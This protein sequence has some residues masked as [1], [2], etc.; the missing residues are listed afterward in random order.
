[1]T[2]L[3]WLKLRKKTAP[4]LPYE[5]PIF[6]GNKSNGEFFHD[7]TPQERRIRAEIL[8][9]CD[10]KARKLGMDR[11]EF[12]ASAMGMCTSL[13]VL[14]LAS[15]CGDKGGHMP[16][17]AADPIMGGSQANAGGFGGIGGVGGVNAAGGSGGG[18][19]IAMGPMA[20]AGVGGAGGASG[21]DAGSAMPMPDGEC[22]EWCD[23]RGQPD[24]GFCIPREATLDCEMADKLLG[25]DEF[26]FDLQT[27]HVNQGEAGFVL[28][29]CQING[30][31]GH[32][33][34]AQMSGNACAWP[35]NYVEQIFLD[36]DTTVAVLSGLPS[37]VSSTTG[38]LTGFSNMDMVES[39][40][41][42]NMAAASQ[43]MV[44]HCQV[45]PDAN[46]SAVASM[47]ERVHNELGHVGWKCYPPA[48]TGGGPWWLDGEVGER[49]IQKALD[50]GDPLI[51]AHKGFPLP[52]FDAVYCDPKDVGPAA[53]KFSAATFIIYHSAYGIGVSEGPYSASGAGVDRLVKTVEEHS[54]RRKNVYAEMGS[55]WLLASGNPM[56]A[57]HYVGK[58]LKHIG[59]DRLLW[60]SECVWF[61]SP[62][63][64]IEAFRTFT[65][66]KEFQEMYG[67]PEL[68]PQLKAGIF[69]LNAAKLYCVD[70]NVCRYQVD[71]SLLAQRKRELDGEFGP[72]RWAFEQPA[73]K[74]RR[75]FI[76]LIK[77]KRALGELG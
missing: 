54:L 19:P 69:G 62:Q 40:T 36:S 38:D 57:Q 61:G 26:I 25:G 18:V 65:I 4:E 50:L 9:R 30:M 10:D 66:S 43:R 5:P 11:R 3:P 53:V 14:N 44:N 42:I 49:F 58:M 24:G 34:D 72:R 35:D 27:H 39:R 17:S 68:T 77:R 55:A 37:S 41:R 32:A 73:I 29:P 76:T 47:M 74:T 33:G 31:A 46:W 67:Y 13:S 51:C 15:G 52:G 71:A 8:R 23:M 45:G 2:K 59:E 60:G 22:A 16:I 7:Q 6:L 75:D 63:R 70:P 20:G 1:M 48:S 28:S 21:M 64:Q 12:I 56:T